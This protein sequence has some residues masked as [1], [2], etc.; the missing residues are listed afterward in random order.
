M[1]NRRWARKI[2][3]GRIRRVKEVMDSVI[4]AVEEEADVARVSCIEKRDM[5]SYL[6]K[7][8]LI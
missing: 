7:L 4:Q 1:A 8:T 3:T 6:Q 5:L 2:R